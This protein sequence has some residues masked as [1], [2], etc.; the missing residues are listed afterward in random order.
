MGAFPLL[1]VGVWGIIGTALAV[2][3]RVLPPRAAASDHDA[4]TAARVATLLLL[5]GLGAFVNLDLLPETMD[6]RRVAANAALLA[7][8]LGLWFAVLPALG[9]GS[10]RGVFGAL[11]GVSRGLVVLSVG[12]AAVL[13]AVGYRARTV[14][15]SPYH[16]AIAA[17]PAQ[18]SHAPRVMVL[19]IDG[20][21]WDIVMPLIRRG[22]LPQIRGLMERGTWGVFRSYPK[23]FSPVVWTSI[24]TGRPQEEHGVY[25]I[26]SERRVKSVWQIA[27]EAGL[28]AAVVN[29]PGTYP[30]RGDAGIMCAGFPLPARA[31]LGNLGWMATTGDATTYERGPLVTRLDLEPGA[32]G[33]EERIRISLKLRDLPVSAPLHD[34]A[35]FL[36]LRAVAGEPFA[37]RVQRTFASVGFGQIELALSRDGDR[38]RLEGAEDEHLFS[39]QPGEWSEW[40]LATVNGRRFTFKVHFVDAAGDVTLFV[41]PFFTLDDERCVF[42]TEPI[43]TALDPPYVCEGAGWLLFQEPRL[44]ESLRSHLMD[45]AW[46]RSRAGLSILDRND[47]DLFVYVF[48]ITD[49]LQ[50]PMLKFMYPEPYRELAASVGGD[51]VLFEP[52]PEQVAEFGETIDDAYRAVDRW[53]GEMLE[54]AGEETMVVIVSDHGAAPGRYDPR[55]TGGAHHPDGIYVVAPAKGSAPE[56]HAATASA[57]FVPGDESFAPREGPALVLED[58]TPVIL[59][60]LG[61]PVAEDMTGRLPEFLAGGDV[62][63]VASYEGEGAIFEGTP[64]ADAGVNEQ[65]RS[66]GYLE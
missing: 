17:A 26:A 52:T 23:S 42:P 65:I 13:T 5:I 1:A 36:L 12:G 24:M 55:P 20:A 19:G 16:P 49:R 7:G 3:A 45:V 48:T 66:L 51:Y 38:L 33:P 37:Y 56:V 57:R 14:D 11:A 8:A 29:V 46:S 6:A 62:K 4:W 9:R 15:L 32:L 39:L 59:R 63:S 64:H 40:L 18:S 22:D 31:T 44:L 50:H 58:A 34:T 10:A 54:R 61:L 35:P 2:A 43:A 47:L 53:I 25:K 27:T 30:I 28:R 41:T 60:L 21:T